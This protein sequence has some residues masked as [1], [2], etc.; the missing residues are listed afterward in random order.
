[1]E[2]EERVVDKVDGGEEDML[3]GDAVTAEEEPPDEGRIVARDDESGALD[4]TKAKAGGSE[5]GPALPLVDIGKIKSILD[6]T[7]HK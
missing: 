2:G 3:I 4:W 7:E 5:A 6:K 1:V